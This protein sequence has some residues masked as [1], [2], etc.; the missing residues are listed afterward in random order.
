MLIDAVPEIDPDLVRTSAEW[1]A[2]Q[3]QADAP[4]WGQQSVEVWQGFSDFLVQNEILDEGIDAEAAFT[5]EFLPG[6]VEEN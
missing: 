2:P 6:T 3:Y 4:R 1:L 5:N